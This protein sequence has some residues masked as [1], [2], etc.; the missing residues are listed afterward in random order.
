MREAERLRGVVRD[1]RQELDE[2]Q[3]DAERKLQQL[4]IKH[5]SLR[6]QYDEQLRSLREQLQR[7]RNSDA[8]EAEADGDGGEDERRTAKQL[9]IELARSRQFYQRKIEDLQRRHEAQLRSMKRGDVDSDTSNVSDSASSDATSAAG[10]TGASLAQAQQTVQ[11]LT[12]R[13]ALLE[14]ELFEAS[15]TLG[16]SR[17]DNAR[18][19]AQLE[20]LSQEPRRIAAPELP[21]SPTPSLDPAAVEKLVE[22][23]VA[24][25]AEDL[26][27]KHAEEVRLMNQQQAST[28]ASLRESLDRVRKERRIASDVRAEPAAGGVS[29]AEAQRLR[30]ELAAEKKRS[31]VL[32]GEI[33]RLKGE[34]S[35]QPLKQSPLDANALLSHQVADLQRRI[36][37]REHEL[38]HVIAQAQAQARLER[39]RLEL[40]HAAELRVKDEQLL[41]F[42][43]ELQQLVAA[44]SGGA[45]AAAPVE[46]S[47][48]IPLATT[49]P[50]ASAEA[51]STPL[52]T[53]QSP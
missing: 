53:L 8:R 41:Q 15:E 20:S 30:D 18:L 45:E 27:R 43:L 34:V 46:G 16:Q 7:D 50:D 13:L 37:V 29:D 47:G 17:A 14:K 21:L 2:Q 42:R 10:G 33:M 49:V 40:A 11:Q 48:K 32:L 19:R 25:L 4:R 3:R 31:S 36:A 52:R 24:A 22:A 6:T 39:Q 5:D 44:L 28:V 26:R 12:Q 23:Q 38:T 35:A 51:L 9:T 1:L